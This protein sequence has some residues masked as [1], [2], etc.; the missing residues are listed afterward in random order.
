M[1][2]ILDS[3]SGEKYLNLNSYD[4]IEIGEKNNHINI[5][6]FKINTQEWKY[7]EMESINLEIPS[8]FTSDER[9]IAIQT[10]K[11]Y[12]NQLINPFEFK[13]EYVKTSYINK[14]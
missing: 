7:V 13:E 3:I 9:L 14:L 8:D 11:E 12:L 4:K 1:N 6:F 10:V 5:K 2:F